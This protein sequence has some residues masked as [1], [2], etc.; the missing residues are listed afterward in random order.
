M[1]VG[2]VIPSGLAG[3]FV[4]WRPED[5]WSRALELARLTER[6]GFAHVWVADHLHGVLGTATAPTF[7]AF[8]LLTAIAGQTT[9][10]R[11]GPG[12]ACAAFRNP[13]L[14]VKMAAT[15]DVASGGRLDLALGAGWFEPE[16]RVYGYGFPPASGRLA[17]LRQTLEVVTAM[18]G[19]GSAVGLDADPSHAPVCVPSGLQQ[20]RIRIVVGGNGQ[21]VTWRLAARF[22][23]E[24]N[25][26]GPDPEQLPAW[27]RVIEQRCAEVGRDPATLAVSAQI[28]WDG[29]VG[30]RRVEILQR[31]ADQR[32]HRIVSLVD[33][34]AT[35]DEPVYAFAE[36]CRAAGL[37]LSGG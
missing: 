5:A 4:D 30:R 37:Q 17:I 14:L 20:P 3:E 32:L 6:L 13:A 15:L 21:E 8:T 9:R 25:V 26:D 11:L 31:L 7:E 27:R 23:D 16:W 36:D 28:W 35:S 2:V 29:A 19:P 10:V 24:L 1:Q 34:A 18:L 12:V 33:G 22:A